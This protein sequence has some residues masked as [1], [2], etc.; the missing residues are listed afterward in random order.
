MKPTIIFVATHPMSVKAFLLPHIRLLKKSF[1]I[2][3]CTNTEQVPFFQSIPS[4]LDIISLPLQRSIS[5][6]LDFKHLISLFLFF[7]K[8]R[9]LAVHTITPKSGLLGMFAAWLAGVPVRVHSFTGQ[10]WVTRSGLSRILLKFA[11]YLIGKFSTHQLPDS[12]SQLEFLV[13][14]N[15]L[16][17]NNAACLG[18]GSIC[19]VDLNRFFPCPAV[20]RE[21]RSELGTTSTAFVCL[22]LG[23]LTRDKGIYDLATAFARVSS[24]H[25]DCEL[26]IVGPDEGTHFPAISQLLAQSIHRVKRVGLTFEPERYMQAADL[27]CL[28]SYR[29]G[30]GSSVIEAA[31][32]GTP[33]LASRIYGLTDAV[34]EGQ[35]GWMFSPGNVEELSS[36][37]DCLISN[38]SVVASTGN[39]ARKYVYENFS[40]DMITRKMFEFYLERL[41]ET[42][43]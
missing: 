33:T 41:N 19:G 18:A 6:F 14:Q 36:Q 7:R 39:L 30:F 4:D 43:P 22:F 29:E 23:R 40:E 37:L 5:I 9:P 13:A 17:P 21:V 16:S 10:V 26:W 12:P 31:S 27:F 38:P 2:L 35:T 34:L 11:D 28:P 24:L 3:V 42:I 32:C 1:S 25:P 15:V 20:K 8:L